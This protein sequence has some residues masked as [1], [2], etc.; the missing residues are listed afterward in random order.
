[1][2]A[3]TQKA[4]VLILLVMLVAPLSR[5]VGHLVVH[6]EATSRASAHKE[7]ALDT[8][9]D[10]HILALAADHG[11]GSSFL[12]RA[13]QMHPCVLQIGEP[14]SPVERWA[15]ATGE[16]AFFNFA[17][18]PG[19]LAIEEKIKHN[20]K[21]AAEWLGCDNMSVDFL[22]RPSAKTSLFDFFEEIRDQFLAQCARKLPQAC[23]GKLILGHKMFPVYVSNNHSYVAPYLT[24]RNTVVV[25]MQ[26]NEV[27]RQKSCIRRFGGHLDGKDISDWDA[28]LNNKEGRGLFSQKPYV[29]VHV[30]DMWETPISY[31][32]AVERFLKPFNFGKDGTSLMMPVRDFVESQYERHSS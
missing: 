29:H 6:K 18:A 17:G 1:V 9:T 5:A 23:G 25:H 4:R 13:L 16:N 14:F 21:L 12:S 11:T 28:Y 10:L 3:A 27:D 8:D 26:R 22:D 32:D 31:L 7:A 20:L 19:E 30:E 2:M 24:S 15:S